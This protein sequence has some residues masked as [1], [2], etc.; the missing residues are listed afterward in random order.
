MML[1]ER[2]V[3]K[4]YELEALA[5]LLAS[6]LGEEKAGEAVRAAARELGIVAARPVNFQQALEIFENIA[7]TPGIIGVTAR[8]AKSRLH[9]AAS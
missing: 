9:L 3:E 2:T 1:R 8:F 6:S 5:R 4:T 7:Q